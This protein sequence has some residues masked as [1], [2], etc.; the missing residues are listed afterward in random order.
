MVQETGVVLHAAIKSDDISNV[1]LIL[2]DGLDPNIPD[3]SA[4]SGLATPLIHAAWYDQPEIVQML[5]AA[6]ADVDMK[7]GNGLTPLHL[8]AH[9]A[10][11]K[12][13]QHLL[14][15]G[16]DP[17]GRGP[18]GSTALHWAAARKTP[19]DASR[20]VLALLDAGVD[21]AVRDDQGRTAL[22]I[23]RTDPALAET[24]GFTRLREVSLRP[25]ARVPQSVGQFRPPFT[26]PS[27]NRSVADGSV[28]SPDRSVSP[29][30]LQTPPDDPVPP[31]ITHNARKTSR[32]GSSHHTTDPLSQRGPL[33]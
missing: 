3:T 21:P 26:R 33:L 5:I 25:P 20:I 29:R 15:A 1:R 8:V 6:G 4:P 31:Q 13:V 9:R 11:T 14:A 2:A 10:S 17:N 23:A 7:N 24:D 16:A 12:T 27:I 32:R 19:G 22:M 28:T 18:Q 30:K